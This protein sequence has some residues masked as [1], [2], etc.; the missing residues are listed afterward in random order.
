MS[1]LRG[2]R[3]RVPELFF[4]LLMYCPSSVDRK[5]FSLRLLAIITLCVFWSLGQAYSQ[6]APGNTPASPT[7]G[8]ALSDEELLK[9]AQNP[10]ADLIS[11]PILNTTNFNIGPYNRVQNVLAF[12]PVIPLNLS[13]NWMLINRIILPITWQPY[14]DKGSGGQFGLGDMAPSFFLAP[15]NPGSV[16]WGVGPAMGHPHRN[17]RH[18]GTG[19]VQSWPVRGRSGSARPVDGGCVGEQHMVRGGIGWSSLDQSNEL[20][21]FPRL[22]SGRRLVS[23]IRSDLDRGLACE[24]KGRMAC[25]VRRR[26]GETGYFR[27]PP[28]RFFCNVLWQPYNSRW[29]TDL[30]NEFAGNLPIPSGTLSRR[31]KC[32]LPNSSHTRPDDPCRKRGSDRV[33]LTE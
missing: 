12:Q 31:S 32:A 28:C 18:S 19:Q 21:V 26:R 7:K 15:R 22:Q 29:R 25:A 2:T 24:A 27:D 17:Q 13:D 11:V 14:P 6:D 5:R 4:R 20:A 8:T 1:S 30:A 16:I 3:V 9:A 10:V 23:D 33:N